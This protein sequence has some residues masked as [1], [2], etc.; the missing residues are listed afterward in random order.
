MV[1]AVGMAL[2]PA[3]PAAQRVRSGI[4]VPTQ[5]PR[6]DGPS[7]R[8][9]LLLGTSVKVEAYPRTRTLDDARDADAAADA[10]LDATA[11]ADLLL[12]TYRSDSELARV[13]ASAATGPVAVTPAL[14][15]LL[16]AALRLATL[17]GGA[18]DPTVRPLEQLWAAG[19]NP[20]GVEAVR[21]AR[22]L[23]G[24]DHVHL[25]VAAHTIGFDRAGV[26][27]ELGTLAKGFAADVARGV[28]RTRG[29]SGLVDTGGVQA[30]SGLPPG[31]AYWTIGVA[32]PMRPDTLLGT[33]DLASGA[34][35]TVAQ[36]LPPLPGAPPRQ[37]PRIDPRDGQ[38]ARGA[39]SAT[40]VAP[41]GTLAG[42][43][44]QALLVLDVAHGHDLLRHYPKTWAVV[45][46]QDAAGRLV[47]SVTDGHQSSFHPAAR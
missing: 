3:S 16:D 10:A 4:P 25:N 5:L 21:A 39:V 31:K 24:A 19:R 11:A 8:Y 18:F 27:L 20:P 41:D 1:A 32:H 40:V 45:V 15:T 14:A 47:T 13:N 22:A 37:A 28:L 30:V 36:A 38:P 44:A 7:R 29:V 26:A 17:S 23:T 34:V 6:V 43:L 42:G 46:T 33:V 35:A 12:N 2:T 9:R